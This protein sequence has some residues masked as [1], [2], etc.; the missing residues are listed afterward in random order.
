MQNR[1]RIS[2]VKYS[3][4]QLIF[5]IFTTLKIIHH[6]FIGILFCYNFFGVMAKTDFIL[7][8]MLFPAVLFAFVG[9]LVVLF[10]AG[11]RF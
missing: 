11:V 10:L 3:I 5:I 7:L 6:Q 4:D 9:V 1:M 2:L 8:F